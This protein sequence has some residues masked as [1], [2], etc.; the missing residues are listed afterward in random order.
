LSSASN[1]TIITITIII[2]TQI[3]MRVINI[4]INFIAWIWLE[5]SSSHNPSLVCELI[6]QLYST[7]L[8]RVQFQPQ[9][10]TGVW[11]NKSTSEGLSRE[12]SSNGDMLLYIP[13]T[14]KEASQENEERFSGSQ[15]RIVNQHR[16]GVVSRFTLRDIPKRRS[17]HLWT[18]AFGVQWILSVD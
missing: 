18:E 9:P 4:T 15:G 14:I 13:H 16:T 10:L 3:N 1:I 8:T 2:I 7:D 12:Q 17:E 6:N 5:P 11:A